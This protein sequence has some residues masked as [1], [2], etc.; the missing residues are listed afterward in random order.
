M[1]KII[2]FY[3][4]FVSATATKA[5][6]PKWEWAQCGGGGTYSGGC[7][8]TIS[9]SGH[10][11]LGAR[12]AQTCTFG[13]V[14]ATGPGANNV[15]HGRFDTSGLAQCKWLSPDNF[16]SGEDYSYG[17]AMDNRENTY[18]VGTINSGYGGLYLDKY[19]SSGNKIWAFNPT[20]TY[21]TTQMPAAYGV[22]SDNTNDSGNTYIVG[23]YYYS[24]T[25]PT[26]PNPTVLNAVGGSDDIFLAKIDSNGVPIWAVSAGGTGTD[27]GRGIAI[28]PAGYIYIC[29]SYNATATFG[30]L[31]P[32][33]P[34]NAGN[35]SLFVAKYDRSGNA[36]WVNTATNSGF[37]APEWFWRFQTMT[38]DSCGNS[39]VT[40][41]Y[42]N[43]A[44]FGSNS[45]TSLAGTNGNIYIAKLL[46]NGN[47]E[48]VK[49]AGGTGGDGAISVALDKY[50]DVYVS[51]AIGSATAK[52]DNITVTNPAAPNSN[53]FVAKYSNSNGA[54]QWVLDASGS[55][56]T[57]DQGIVVDNHGYI[58]ISG[59]IGGTATL[60]PSTITS[61][62]GGFNSN[63]LL[64]K[65][66]TVP[67]RAI[68]PKVNSTYCPGSTVPLPYTII[69][70]FNQGN[71]FTAQ[72]SDSTGSFADAQNIGDTL[73]SDS[74]SINIKIPSGTPTGTY[75]IRVVSDSPS[76][77]SW[78]NGCGAYY[79]G[80]YINDFYVS[81][82]NSLN[83]SI[84]SS[85]DSLCA[86]GSVVLNATGVSGVTYK[87][88]TNADTST[89]A[90]TD[91]TTVNPSITT[92]YYLSVSNGYCSGIDSVTIN[93]TPVTNLDIEP[94]DTSFCSGQ[95]ATLHINGGGSGFIWNPS[96]GLNVDT[97]SI[98]IA[99][100]TVTT[101]Y[102]VTGTS[103]GCAAT[104]ADVVGVVPSPNMPTFTQTGNTLMSS[105]QFDNQ[106]YRNDSLL[107]NDTSQDLTVTIPGEY[108]VIVTN[109]AN[110]CSTSSDSAY[111]KLSGI[112]QLPGI[113]NQVSVY[114]NP[115]NGIIFIRINSSAQDVKDWNLQITDVLGR[116]VYSKQSLNYSNDIDLSNL[117]NGIYFITVINKTSRAV[118]PVVRQN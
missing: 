70:T 96:F 81:I 4:I 93:V 18:L 98:V 31:P 61:G 78:A 65:I 5:Q 91:S 27:G 118:F 11:Y 63:V 38:V 39:Y 77:S 90:T 36:L 97:G 76:T 83:V 12:F 94:N 34:A 85:T 13:G 49:S 60:G 21:P 25:F 86:G 62:G 33:P 53:V 101:T 28:D 8:V 113:N 55:G 7:G 30:S 102:T 29:G 46:T 88:H 74:G 112:E 95:S 54:A 110:G 82:G 14:T 69:G 23:E 100:P 44:Q 19:D 73:S 2:L 3:L 35:A 1:K 41:T 26:V 59:S 99:S 92:T 51:G 105:S 109:E 22:A 17:F 71:T 64:A 68:I 111:V 75:L 116:T 9:P 57:G 24:I 43:T 117:S 15:L 42:I 66:D 45:I 115:F 20:P 6:T 32:T 72:L 103:S 79:N 104:G 40:G 67:I 58:Y 48:W 16:S 108:R 87:W 10:L 106:W 52:F 84:A 80:V 107:V 89:F 47:W 37:L 50:S 56:G 114:P